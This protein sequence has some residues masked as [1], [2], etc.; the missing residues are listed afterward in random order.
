MQII[1]SFITITYWIPFLCSFPHIHIFKSFFVL[2]SFVFSI[3]INLIALNVIIYHIHILKSFLWF[4]PSYFLFQSFFVFK[5]FCVFNPPK[6]NNLILSNIT[7]IYWIPF[8]DSFLH[9][10]FFNYLFVSTIPI[11][12]LKRIS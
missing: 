11:T 10:Q 2:K 12:K 6:H 1:L 9:I 8:Y 3:H 7:I 4:L 5:I